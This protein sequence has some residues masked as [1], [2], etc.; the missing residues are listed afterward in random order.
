[1]KIRH[2]VPTFL[3]PTLLRPLLLLAM[4]VALAGPPAVAQPTVSAQPPLSGD[5]ALGALPT[6]VGDFPWTHG[7]GMT[8]DVGQTFRAAT[9]FS[10]QGV[11]VQVK[12]ESGVAGRSV[13]FQVLELAPGGD[14]ATGTP[15]AIAVD[16]LPT[17]LAPG[18]TLYL[19]LE[20]P[21]PVSLQA[22]GRYAFLLQF[23]G[24]GDVNLA[25]ARLLHGGDVYAGGTAFED[26]GGFVRTLPGDLVFLLHGGPSEAPC[27]EDGLTLCLQDERFRLSAAFSSDGVIYRG[28]GTHRM[29][30][31][32]GYFWFFQP[33][34]VELVTKVLAGCPVNER[35]WVFCAGMTNVEVHLRVVDT[36][37]EPREV[38][39]YTNLQHTP[40]QPILDAA[41]FATCP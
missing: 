1:M 25:R 41:A 16:R 12:A 40:F 7:T 10:L 37:S 17:A 11:T 29:T 23:E 38:Q 30:A 39:D 9:D 36:E 34:N 35:F 3:R 26:S 13:A 6:V 24:G 22:D 14:P 32:S 27:L 4:V 20:W 31:D 19:T 33:A 8:V 21:T 28:A 2:T 18:V 15:V 5:V